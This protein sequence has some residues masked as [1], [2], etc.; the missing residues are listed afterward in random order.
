MKDFLLKAAPYIVGSILAAVLARGRWTF[1]MRGSSRRW[2]SVRGK[3][4]SARIVGGLRPRDEDGQRDEYFE[5]EVEYEYRVGGKEYRGTRYSFGVGEFSRYDD[6]MA[7]LRGI[8]AVREVP[9]Y[10]DPARPERAV[11]RKG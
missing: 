7:A 2:P 8:A 1:R 6:A 5:I 4:R 3:V 11:L 10:Y 9:V